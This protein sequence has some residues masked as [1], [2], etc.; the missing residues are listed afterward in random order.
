VHVSAS[1]VEL[2]LEG[3]HE[4]V[5]RSRAFTRSSL[6]AHPGGVAD[7]AALVVT[8]LVTNALLHGSP[9]VRLRLQDVRDGVRLE[10]AD[11]G[12]ELPVAVRRSSV[13]MTGR[14]LALVDALSRSWGVEQDERGGKVVW[15]ELAGDGSPGSAPDLPSQD[16]DELLDAFAS[17]DDVEP[18]HT[19]ELGAVP[20]DLLLDAKA[21]IDNLV[22]EFTLEAAAAGESA[23]ASGGSVPPALAEL[24]ATVV[25]GFRAARS[26]IKRQALEAAARDEPEVHLVL[27]LPA[28]A[29]DAGERYLAALEE[30]DEWAAR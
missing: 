25:H 5:P 1:A 11:G 6:V 7:D 2:V 18:L 15:A 24:V 12:T 13:A 20:T 22:R 3:G 8:E 23:S 9:P 19:V 26:A 16:L 21:H 4:D 30:A 17:D 27:T 14:G 28:S 10:V 29:A